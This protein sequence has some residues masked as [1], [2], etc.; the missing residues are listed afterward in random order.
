MKNGKL[1]VGIVGLGFGGEFPTIYRDHPL[2][3]RVV[4]CDKDSELLNGYGD[5]FGFEEKARS[6]DELLGL[7][8]D[9]VHIVTDI[10]THQE[11]TIRTLNAGKHCACTVPM[12][13]SVTELRAII[14]AQQR[15]RKNYMMMETSVYTRQCLFV[16]E[17]LDRGEIGNIQF[18]RGTHFQDMEGWP[19]YWMGLPPMHYAT[20]AVA[21]LLFL[22]NAKAVKVS[23]VGSGR[24]REALTMRYGNP[25]PIETAIVKLDTAG[26]CAEVTRSLF[27]TAR[28]YVEGFTVLGDKASFEWNVEDENPLLFRFG[29][30]IRPRQG[31]EISCSRIECPDYCYTLPEPIRKYTTQA[32]G[33][34]R[35][36]PVRLK[37]QGAGHHGSHPHLVHEFLQSIVECRPPRVDA[38]IAANWTAAGICAHESA[39]R[40]GVTVDVPV[41]EKRGKRELP[42]HGSGQS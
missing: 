38:F 28:Q 4:I 41:F 32:Q 23:C 26:L 8:L 12:A 27:H 10:H 6:F 42:L 13:T 31:R 14:E 21:P 22:S 30:A 29:D 16:K 20:H 18:L 15:S 36:G 9:A 17:L 7:D 39:M 37:I 5:A 33:H 40:E 24:M 2:V 1:S 19:D 11:L 35:N 25:Y 34:V 3:E